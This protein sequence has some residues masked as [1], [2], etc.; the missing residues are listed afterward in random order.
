[1]ELNGRPLCFFRLEVIRIELLYDDLS[2]SPGIDLHLQSLIV[3]IG[4]KGVA[5]D[6][7]P[8]E[9]DEVS[10]A[11]QVV[12]VLHVIVREVQLHQC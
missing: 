10:G 9:R 7:E 2:A 1:M 5:S 12:L 3:I 11:D 8:L 4:G 6:D